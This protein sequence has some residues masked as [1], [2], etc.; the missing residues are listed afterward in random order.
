MADNYWSK[1]LVN[2][3]KK[4]TGTTSDGSYL[5][6]AT[7][8]VQARAIEQGLG[9][10]ITLHETAFG[11][12]DETYYLFRTPETGLITG[13]IMGLSCIDNATRDI[14]N[15]EVD[16]YEGATVSADGA[17]TGVIVTNYNR[18]ST[19]TANFVVKSNPTITDN[20]DLIIKSLVSSN[21][22]TYSSNTFQLKPDTNYLIYIDNISDAE[23]QYNISLQ[24]FQLPE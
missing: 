20:G 8:S 24:A 3:I 13:V 12:T 17:D 21:F 9:Y 15:L 6:L 16:F 1:E 22:H 2:F 10:S 19:E 11:T 7:E 4:T 23:V 18:N 14:G 5:S